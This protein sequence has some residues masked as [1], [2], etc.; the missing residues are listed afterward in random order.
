MWIWTQDLAVLGQTLYHWAGWHWSTKPN[1]YLP[2]LDRFWFTNWLFAPEP[3]SCK[4]SSWCRPGKD[5]CKCSVYKQIENV[6]NYPWALYLE[7][8]SCDDGQARR[9]R[10]STRSHQHTDFPSYLEECDR[11]VQTLWNLP[12]HKASVGVLYA[13][14]PAVELKQQQKLLE[15]ELELEPHTTTTRNII[16]PSIRILNYI[17][18]LYIQI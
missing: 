16:H 9:P 8:E 5:L 11:D 12:D 3:K 10:S 6:L 17:T 7:C 4:D 2:Q 15:L 14:L 18:F 13:R 1:W